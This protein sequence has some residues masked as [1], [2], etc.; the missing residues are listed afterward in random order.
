MF[1]LNDY[2]NI[3]IKGQLFSADD[4]N[5]I[6]V[7]IWQWVSEFILVSIMSKLYVEYSKI[8]AQQ[9]VCYRDKK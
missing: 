2:K 1:S 6:E 4:F 3:S 5:E 9:T 8:N 7:K